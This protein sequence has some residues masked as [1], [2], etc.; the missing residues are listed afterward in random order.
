MFFFVFFFKFSILLT[1]KKTVRFKIKHPTYFPHKHQA[2]LT[3]FFF[4]YKHSIVYSSMIEIGRKGIY[5]YMAGAYF[6]DVEY[7]WTQT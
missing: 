6:V 5:A 1:S 7:F 2:L 4:Y 3:P